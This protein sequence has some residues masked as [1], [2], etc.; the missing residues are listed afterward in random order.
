VDILAAIWA[1][2]SSSENDT[3]A[4]RSHLL[5]LYYK[6]N[7]ALKDYIGRI[8]LAREGKLPPKR[9]EPKIQINP[10]L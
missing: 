3:E 9:A 10:D 4:A 7:P 5:Q 8:F 1:N 6:E 2:R